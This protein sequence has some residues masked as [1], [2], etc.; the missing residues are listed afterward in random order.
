VHDIT[1]LENR[2]IPG[3]FIASTEFIEA[4]QAQATALG[5]DTAVVFVPHPIQD[6]TD[7]EMQALADEALTSILQMIT[8]NNKG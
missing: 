1:N 4:A 7:E 2:G 8:A 6:Q 3:V 5:V